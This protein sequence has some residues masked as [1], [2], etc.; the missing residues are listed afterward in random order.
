MKRMWLAGM[1]LGA[2]LALVGTASAQDITVGVAGPMTG[3][4]ASF[5]TQLRNGAEAAVADT[6]PVSSSAPVLLFSGELDPN[7]PARWA[8]RAA[9]TL[10][11][12]RHVV[13]PHVAHNF[14]SVD[15]GPSIAEK[16]WRFV[17][18]TSTT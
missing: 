16:L 15:M 3:Q 6:T 13:L 14:S 17:A 4:Y 9:R 8:E 18:P 5:G 2:S 12:S 11:N 1:A 10:P 7:T